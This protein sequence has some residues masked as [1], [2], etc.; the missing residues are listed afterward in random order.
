MA[1]TIAELRDHVGL[2]APQGNL[3]GDDDAE[4]LRNAAV[5]FVEHLGEALVID[6]G[7]VPYMNSS[8]IGVLVAIHTT[9]K[10]RSRR[11]VLC[12]INEK[13]LGIF[14]I[15]KLAMVF[16][17]YGTRADALGGLDLPDSV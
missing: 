9:Y 10:R 15:T 14:T 11:V 12:N 16:E 1:M 13:L 4:E 3:L 7:D 6:L 8:G 2:I 5:D 17:V